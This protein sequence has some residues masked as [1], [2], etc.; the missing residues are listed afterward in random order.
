M[1][2]AIPCSE[3]RLT[4]ASRISARAEL[5]PSP[6]L[7]GPT[8]EQTK[9]NNNTTQHTET[10]TLKKPTDKLNTGSTIRTSSV[11]KGPLGG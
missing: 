11:P 7:A 6:Q 10:G 4:W 5:S 8:M 1:D 3:Y 2:M 9:S